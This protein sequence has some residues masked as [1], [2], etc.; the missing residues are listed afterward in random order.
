MNQVPLLVVTTDIYIY[1]YIYGIVKGANL[2][3]RKPHQ[4]E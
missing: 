2:K 1:I 4:A 3:F